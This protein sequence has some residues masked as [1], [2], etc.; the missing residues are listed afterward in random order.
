MTELVLPTRAEVNRRYRACTA[1]DARTL[2]HL[3][4]LGKRS[5]KEIEL[6]TF[7][8]CLSNGKRITKLWFELLGEDTEEKSV[9][10]KKY[11]AL[12]QRVTTLEEELAR[13]RH[14]VSRALA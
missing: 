9:L 14:D 11:E 10:M 6:R 7:G 3:W 4:H 2:W 8:D 13:L 12:A 5:K 1:E